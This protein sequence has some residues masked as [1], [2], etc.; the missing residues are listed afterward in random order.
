MLHVKPKPSRG[1]VG[2]FRGMKD[3]ASIDKLA[4]F[5]REVNEVVG[6]ITELREGGGDFEAAHGL[7][8]AAR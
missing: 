7:L 6:A 8:P 1:D 3:D 5:K 4:K 2:L